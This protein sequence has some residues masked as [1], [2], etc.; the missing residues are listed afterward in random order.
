MLVFSEEVYTDLDEI[1]FQKFDQKIPEED[2][3]IQ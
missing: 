1:F 2:T 3:N